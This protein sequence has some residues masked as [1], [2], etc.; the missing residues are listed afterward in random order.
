MF[1]P[2]VVIASIFACAFIQESYERVAAALEHDGQH[3]LVT[4]D[5]AIE[6]L[7]RAHT[8]GGFLFLRHNTM[9][10]TIPIASPVSAASSVI[11]QVALC[12]VGNGGV[13]VCARMVARMAFMV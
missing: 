5:R 6:V 2:W 9:Q 10:P 13:F 7:A 12:P 4:A 8:V 1:V 3:L 11:L